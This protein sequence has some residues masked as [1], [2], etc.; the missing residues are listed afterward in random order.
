[1]RGLRLQVITELKSGFRR[2]TTA[3]MASAGRRSM[4]GWPA[5]TGMVRRGLVPCVL[6]QVSVL[7]DESFGALEPAVELHLSALEGVALRWPTGLYM[8]KNVG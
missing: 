3:S 2:E 5:M 4:G 7:H 8:V 1:M 6:R